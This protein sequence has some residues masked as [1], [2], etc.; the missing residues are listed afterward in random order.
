LPRQPGD[1]GPVKTG[2]KSGRS[3]DSLSAPLPYARQVPKPAT[4]KVTVQLFGPLTIAIGERRIGPRDLG[5]IRPKQVLEILLA[6]RGRRVPTDRLADLLWGQELP[7]DARG[8]LQTFVSVLRRHLSSDREWARALVVTEPEAYRVDT[9]LVEIDLDRFDEL[10]ERAAHEPAHVARR[11]LEQALALVPG[12]VLEDEPY[13]SWAEEL[14]GVYQARIL[15]ARLDAAETALVACDY[16]A[17]LEHADEAIGMDRFGER[18]QQLAMVALY[19]LGRQHEALEAYRRLRVHLDKELGLEPLPATRA[20]QSSILRQDDVSALLPRPSRV[21]GGRRLDAAP[22]TFL[23]RSNEFGTLE[24]V[25]R[26]A[27]EGSFSLVLIEGEAGFGKSRV[28]DELASSLEGARIGRSTCSELERHLPYV[29]LATAIREALH[30]LMPEPGALPALREILPE[31]RVDDDGRA[32]AEVDALES[33]VGLVEAH[34]PL[35][36]L[37]DDLQWADPSTLGSI[38][39]IQRRCAAL[40]IAVVGAFRSEEVADGDPLRRLT[41]TA[42][43]RLEPLTKSELA[44]LGISDLHERTGGNPRFVTAAVRQG[45]VGKLEQTLAETL[46][47]RCRAEGVLAYRLLVWASVLGE[48]FEWEDLS[49]VTLLDPLLVT[50]ELERLCA[51]GLLRVDG[52]RFRFRFTIVR[53]VLMH[54]VSPARRRVLREHLTA[55]R[56]EPRPDRTEPQAIPFQR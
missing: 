12:E 43:V 44:P 19:A 54:T 55:A 20:L 7:Q 39:Y 42:V 50:E 56:R 36:L 45:N 28:L 48:G 5:G 32:F 6:A 8:S 23:G 4:A 9:E 38:A 53:E 41:P 52:F 22:I 1:R 10:L 46:L 11:C 26:R 17:A 35:M 40:P 29:P 2:S 30:D 15:G 18:A 51:R 49:K 21:E 37:L 24:R 13:A 25:T 14:R 16:G 31:L 27:L 3:A 33:L 34:A 47:A